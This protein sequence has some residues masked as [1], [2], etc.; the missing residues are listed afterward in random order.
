MSNIE[1]GRHSRSTAA[2]FGIEWDQ[3]QGAAPSWSAWAEQI[4]AAHRRR[5]G[6]VTF[7]LSSAALDAAINGRGFVLAQLSMVS[8]D[9]ASGRLVV[10]FDLRMKLAQPYSLA[11]DPAALDKPLGPELRNWLLQIG[12]R[13]NRLSAPAAG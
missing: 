7:C 13:Q 10:P 5:D 9:L 11:W 2:L 12:R 8:D 4:G 6:E 3:K 1:T